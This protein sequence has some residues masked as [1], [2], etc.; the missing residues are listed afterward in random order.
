VSREHTLEALAT[1]IEELYTTQS[2]NLAEQLSPVQQQLTALRDEIRRG[3]ISGRIDDPM[4]ERIN[5][6]LSLLHAAAYPAG[7][8][9]WRRLAQ[10]REL[11]LECRGVSG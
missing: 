3:H 9:E 2:P 1:T 5:Q 8:V 6:A 11:I 7:A 4:L 10:A